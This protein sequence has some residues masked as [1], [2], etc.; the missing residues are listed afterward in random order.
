[1][2]ILVKIS[3]IFVHVEAFHYRG[4]NI[5][6]KRGGGKIY[7]CFLLEFI[8]THKMRGQLQISVIIWNKTFDFSF[9]FTK[10]KIGRKEEKENMKEISFLKMVENRLQEQQTDFYLYYRFN[11]IKKCIPSLENNFNV[12]HL[13]L[14]FQFFSQ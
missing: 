1:M 6:Y 9:F 12:S 13:E 4:R 8:N 14:C 10:I 11:E 5:L 7:S 3:K 2:F